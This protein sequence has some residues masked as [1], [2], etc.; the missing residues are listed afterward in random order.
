MDT[1]GKGLLESVAPI[2]GTVRAVGDRQAR[3]DAQ[4]RG[5]RRPDRQPQTEHD[6]VEISSVAEDDETAPS[7]ATTTEKP[8]GHLDVAG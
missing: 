2:A 4:P 3:R 7:G 6:A 5:Q 8:S 1:L